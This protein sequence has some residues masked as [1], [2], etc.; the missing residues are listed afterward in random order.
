MLIFEKT[1]K[2]IQG[3]FPGYWFYKATEP[4]YCWTVSTQ[5]RSTYARHIPVSTTVKMKTEFGFQFSQ[6]DCSSFCIWEHHT[7]SRSK[8]TGLRNPRRVGREVFKADSCSS[9][10]MEEL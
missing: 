2:E 5:L 4:T 8:I 6:I 1:S 7:I 3:E 10:L 9:Y